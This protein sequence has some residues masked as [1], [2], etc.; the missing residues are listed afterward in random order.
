ME[1]HTVIKTFTDLDD[2]FYFFESNRMDWVSRGWQECEG[3]G[4][5]YVNHQ[6]QAGLILEKEM[7]G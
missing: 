6:W 2:A 7:D 4:L 3:S 1:R 5:R